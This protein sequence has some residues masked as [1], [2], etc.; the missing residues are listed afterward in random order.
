VGGNSGEPN[1]TV[2]EVLCE[3]VDMAFAAD[4]ALATRFANSAP[5]RGQRSRDLMQHVRDRPGHDRRY[6]LDSSKLRTRLGVT[7]TTDLNDGLRSTVAWYLGNDSWWRPVLSGEYR[8]WYT[9]Q[10]A[11]A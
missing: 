4:P 8:S 6:C 2:V 11:R 9:R 7:A 5:A 1:L 10:Y 3:L